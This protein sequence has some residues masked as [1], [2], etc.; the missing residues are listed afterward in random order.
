[1]LLPPAPQAPP[2]AR[3]GGKKALAKARCPDATATVKEP[4]L[5]SYHNITRSLHQHDH[6]ALR[7]VD[8]CP[9]SLPL[10]ARAPP[11]QA[12]PPRPPDPRDLTIR[13]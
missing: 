7:R 2:A 1:M 9:I 11:P 8:A 5:P 4:V 6:P 3:A 13:I 10:P 12:Q